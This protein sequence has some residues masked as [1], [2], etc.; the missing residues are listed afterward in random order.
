MLETGMQKYK[1]V[2]AETG[3]MDVDGGIIVGGYDR[4]FKDITTG[5]AIN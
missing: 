1:D 2:I 4:K 3:A 5:E